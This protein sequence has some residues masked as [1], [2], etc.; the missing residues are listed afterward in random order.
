MLSIRRINHRQAVVDIAAVGYYESDLPRHCRI[1]RVRPRPCL[2]RREEGAMGKQR[3]T[4]RYDWEADRIAE[5]IRGGSPAVVK[6]E[7]H[8]LT[9]SGLN[10]TLE[11]R[12]LRAICTVLNVHHAWLDGVQVFV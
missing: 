2:T 12:H 5:E 4:T 9:V 11:R 10:W 3:I 6:K 1:V 7:G 8:T